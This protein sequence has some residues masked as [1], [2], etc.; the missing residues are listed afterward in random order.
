M[1]KGKKTGGRVKGQP[2]KVT[3][4]ARKAMELAFEGIGGVEA[5]AKW[6]KDNPDKFYQLWGRM[7]PQQQVHSG[8]P[9]QP[10]RHALIKWGDVEIPI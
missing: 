6:A 7:I 9:E 5:L 3:A 8:D 4:D 1:A 10:I 2:N